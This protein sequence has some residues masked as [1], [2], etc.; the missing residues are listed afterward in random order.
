M[1]AVSALERHTRLDH[2]HR[3]SELGS[4]SSSE[5]V[6]LT[7]QARHCAPAQF[8]SDGALQFD[9]EM[10][11]QMPMLTCGHPAAAALVEQTG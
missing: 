5:I 9:G 7:H 8:G 2:L 4:S 6:S 3:W 1:A 11:L 10:L